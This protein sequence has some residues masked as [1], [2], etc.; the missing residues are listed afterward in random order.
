MFVGVKLNLLFIVMWSYVIYILSASCL[1][2]PIYTHTYVCVD[3][4]IY[5]AIYI[6]RYSYSYLYIYLYLSISIFNLTSI[7]SGQIVM[8]DKV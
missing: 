5:I 2:M 8:S 6:Y 1:H 3:I 7:H 4:Y